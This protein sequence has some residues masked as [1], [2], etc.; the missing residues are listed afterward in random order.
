ME[1]QVVV[2]YRDHWFNRFV[3]WWG[4]DWTHAAV[5]YKTRGNWRVFETAAFGTVEKD[6]EGFIEGVDEYVAFEPIKKLTKTQEIKLISYAW[7]NVGKMYN[8]FVLA[9]I[10]LK[11]LFGGRKPQSFNVTA[12]VCSSF[13]DACF[14]HVGLDLVKGDTVWAT[15]DDLAES[16]LLE[17][18][19]TGKL[20][21]GV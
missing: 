15:P 10:A 16:P 18:V 3:R 19:E 13:T 4:I 5:R 1:I 21:H 8:F 7:G 17:A 14:N 12:H 11:Y 20:D 2:T 9:K 6:W